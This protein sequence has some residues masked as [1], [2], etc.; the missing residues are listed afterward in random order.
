MSAFELDA[1]TIA[2][3]KATAPV[4]AEHVNEI[5]TLF[6]KT[7][8]ANNPEVKAFFNS[9]NQVLEF[10]SVCVPLLYCNVL[11]L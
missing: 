3:I 5:T 11:M 9:R 7:M 6:Y 2:V 1:E 10:T 8:F 4:V